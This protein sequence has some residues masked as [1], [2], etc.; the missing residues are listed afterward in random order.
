MRLA[1]STSSSSGRCHVPSLRGGKATLSVRNRRPATWPARYHARVRRLKLPEFIHEVIDDP[2][3]RNI[4]IAGSL[5]LFAVGLT[6]RVLSPG[7]PTAQDALRNEPDLQSFFLLLAFVS[8]ATIICINT[9]PIASDPLKLRPGKLP[10][11]APS[12]VATGSPRYARPSRK[13]G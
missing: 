3:Q 1:R 6:P 4:L 12:G 11:W 5:A 10:P 13:Q 9:I 8:T 7:L 2:R